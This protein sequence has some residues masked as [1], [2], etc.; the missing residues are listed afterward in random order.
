[1]FL[2][3]LKTTL[4]V[5]IPLFFQQSLLITITCIASDAVKL[6]AVLMGPSRIYTFILGSSPEP[7]STIV[8]REPEEC[9]FLEV[10]EVP[11]PS[12]PLM[13]DPTGGLKGARGSQAAHVGNL[14][15]FSAS[16]VLSAI[17]N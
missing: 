12:L 11:L 3:S 17:I 9:W 5:Y 13:R 6:L 7:K 10:G 15:H 4:A 14:S 1:M 2:T 8:L 16:T